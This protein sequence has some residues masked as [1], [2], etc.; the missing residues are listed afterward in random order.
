MIQ[1]SLKVVS[2]KLQGCA[3][4]VLRVFQGNFRAS[5]ASLKCFNE[6]S[7]VFQKSVVVVWHSSQLPE[8][9]EGLFS[10]E[11]HLSILKNRKIGKNQ[12]MTQFSAPII[13]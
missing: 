6:V 13:S 5:W 2:G 1:T 10:N 3:K 12:T 8:E 4:K 9:K 7:R 11:F